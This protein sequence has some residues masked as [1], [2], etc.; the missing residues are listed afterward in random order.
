MKKTPVMLLIMDGYGLAGSEFGNA[1][2][3]ANTRK[4]IVNPATGNLVRNK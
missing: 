2:K 3:I 4:N 1:I